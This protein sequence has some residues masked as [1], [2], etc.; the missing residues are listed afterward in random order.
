MPVTKIY[1]KCA[2]LRT[3]FLD[4]LT[5]SEIEIILAAGTQQQ[6]RANTVITTQGDPA[7][8]MFLLTKGRARYF[9][10]TQDGHKN[11]LSWFTPG[12]I[13]G[14]AAL[15]MKPSPYFVSAE[16]VRDSSAVVWD[17][18]T[19]REL[20]ARYPKLMENMFMIMA[21]YLNW[22]VATHVALT[23]QTARQRLAQL[24]ICLSPVIGQQ[25]PGGIELEVTNEELASAANIT[26]F[27]TSRLLSEW[28]RSHAIFKNR[29]KIV[30]RASDRLL[31][32]AV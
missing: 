24:L 30:L 8:R 27:T 14:G 9:F 16:A 28:Q 6:F 18:S 29:G 5:P 19:I 23:C 32:P 11:L 7:N 13:F 31:Q 22:Y 21:D 12:H 2:Q 17:S 3:Q 20:A 26:P 25:V 4:G 1:S 15:L 10:M